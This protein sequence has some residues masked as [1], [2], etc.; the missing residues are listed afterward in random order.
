MNIFMAISL[1]AFFLGTFD[2]MNLSN[3]VSS[4]SV[5]LARCK[6]LINYFLVHLALRVLFRYVASAVLTISKTADADSIVS[7]FFFQCPFFSVEC[8]CSFLL[9]VISCDLVK[10]SPCL[11]SNDSNTIEVYII[12]YNYVD[13]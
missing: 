1:R 4:F 8:S 12:S 2:C 3:G 6:I 9:S 10:L 11:V 7:F 5:I 13:Y